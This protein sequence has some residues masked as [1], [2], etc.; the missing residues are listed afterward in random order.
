MAKLCYVNITAEEVSGPYLSLLERLF[1]K[2]AMPDTR[3]DIRCVQPGVNKGIDTTYAYLEFLNNRSIVERIIEAEREGYD[4]AMVGCFLDPGVREARAVANIPVIG[5]GESTM[6]FAC[7]LGHRFAVIAPGEH[8]LIPEYQDNLRLHGLES[9]TIPKPIRPVNIDLDTWIK[10][11]NDTKL[12]ASLVLE[13]A[14]ECAQ[15]GA[16]V[17][18]VGC[19]ALGPFCT[20]SDMVEIEEG[21]VPILDCTSVAVKMAEIMVNM[22]G[23][24]GIPLTSRLGKYVLPREDDLKR[25]RGIFGLEA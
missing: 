9:R 21:H 12:V 11:I 25:V 20:L 17:V 14:K 3:V 19:N 24:L 16:E 2:V 4:A 6:H 13:K 7:L 22:R 18:V 5:L 23:R 1:Q 10:G 8:Q 15:D